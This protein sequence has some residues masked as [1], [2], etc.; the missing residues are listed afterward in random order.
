MGGCCCKAN[1]RY[2][3]ITDYALRS[4]SDESLSELISYASSHSHR[5]RSI[6][7][8]IEVF[9]S[10]ACYR[11]RTLHINNSTHVLSSLVSSLPTHLSTYEF[12]VIRSIRILFEANHPLPA[13][14]LLVSFVKHDSSRHVRRIT[15]FVQC[16][17]HL[18]STNVNLAILTI[19]QLSELLTHSFTDYLPL[20][21]PACF[22]L[23]TF[24]IA[25]TTQNVDD[26]DRV[27]FD[28][29]KLSLSDVLNLEFSNPIY[30]LILF[31]ISFNGSIGVSLFTDSFINYLAK[32]DNNYMDLPQIVLFLPSN[33]DNSS[34]FQA[35]YLSLLHKIPSITPR[36]VN[37]TMVESLLS[38]IVNLSCNVCHAFVPSLG[39]SCSVLSEL[40]L[41]MEESQEEFVDL[42]DLIESETVFNCVEPINLL[43]ELF[44][45]FVR[46][47]MIGLDRSLIVSSIIRNC[48]D[49]TSG[50]HSDRIYICLSVFIKK[51]LIETNLVN[52]KM[53]II[54]FLKKSFYNCL[55]QNSSRITCSM[56]V[57]V[58]FLMNICENVLELDAEFTL[59]MT[60]SLYYL[61]LQLINKEE[62][63]VFYYFLKKLLFI[64]LINQ[65]IISS[66]FGSFSDS[67]FS[68][69]AQDFT[70]NGSTIN[71]F[72]HLFNSEN[73]PELN[74]EL[75]T[76]G[77]EFSQI[78]L[79][80]LLKKLNILE[81]NAIESGNSEVELSQVTDK[82]HEK[83]ERTHNCHSN[84][85]QQIV[86]TANMILNGEGGQ[87]FENEAQDGEILGDFVTIYDH[88]CSIY[89]K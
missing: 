61:A 74:E 37:K 53:P 36:T 87:N 64:G 40:V 68:I 22:D 52:I 73:S 23:M 38:T 54:E 42:I 78:S 6:G 35:C 3:R 84:L 49:Y 2:R 65:N 76:I 80:L 14:K 58:G 43:C 34:L 17:L 27:D 30:S 57:F 45:S 16:I 69:L 72:N 11:N 15:E 56:M 28:F 4:T 83:S 31:L 33:S 21:F 47:D 32:F 67:F 20:V 77:F 25:F 66:L 19:K 63:Y 75:V 62:I 26:F 46:S 24:P 70:L 51:T 5:L 81:G 60:N 1:P 8:Q 7:K 88:L 39:Q 71:S 10:H 89:V 48:I 79:N 55:S 12:H 85:G 50:I 86:S 82:V 59:L 29:D 44:M 41:K 13:T 18:L 9:I